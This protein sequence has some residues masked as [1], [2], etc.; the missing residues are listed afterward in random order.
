MPAPEIER[1][2]PRIDDVDLL[3]GEE[4]VRVGEIAHE[5]FEGIVVVARVH[6]LREVDDCDRAV[7]EEHVVRR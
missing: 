1:V 5:E 2:L 6:G 3:V 7:P 4:G